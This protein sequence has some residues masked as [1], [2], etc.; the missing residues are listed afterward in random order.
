MKKHN[1]PQ[2]RL[3]R[4]DVLKLGGAGVLGTIIAAS[5]L[6]RAGAQTPSVENVMANMKSLTMGE[7]NPNYA[8]QWSY[9]LAQAL[10][11]LQDVGIDDFEVILSEKYMPGLI[12][13][14]LDITHG[15][16]SEFFGAGHAS[17]LPITMISL[18][19]D[20]EWWIMGV[21][22]GVD[23][24]EDL[25]GGKISGGGLQGRN[26]WVMRQVAKKMGLDPNKDV[27]FVPTSGGS[28]KRMA[29]VINGT[30]DGAS[31]FP[32]HRAGLEGAGGKFLF[33]ELTTAPQEGFAAMGDWLEKNEDTAYAWVRADLKARQWLFDPANTER[34]YQ[35]MIDLGYEIPP[36][37]KKLYSVELDQI[38]SDG[39]FESAEAMDQFVEDLAQTG[40]VPKG[41]KWR[42]YVDMKYV[43]AAQKSLGIPKRPVS[44]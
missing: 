17:G 26:T 28:D 41:L 16:T 12:G 39:G 11:Y 19:R 35:I 32:R 40:G 13:G 42:K 20:K 1:K 33:E 38:S 22:K 34:A 18:Y 23:K 31:M 9:R 27:E 2:I 43:W 25:K 10:G 7:F 14:S 8:T 6:N 44:L 4:R 37:F 21:R 30:L 5:T 24:P 36:A 29:A 3:A 15:D